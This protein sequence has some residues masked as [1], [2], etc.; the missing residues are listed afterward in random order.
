MT[1]LLIAAGGIV[2]V[3]LVSTAILVPTFLLRVRLST[4]PGQWWYFGVSFLT[5]FLVTLALY[6]PDFHGNEVGFTFMLA[7]WLGVLMSIFGSLWH[8]SGIDCPRTEPRSSAIARALILLYLAAFLVF[9]AI[10]LH[11][12][13]IA[14]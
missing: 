13:L 12:L 14:S 9:G 11:M 4:R 5:G 3:I 10:A 1:F 7:A 6:A 2:A 8:K